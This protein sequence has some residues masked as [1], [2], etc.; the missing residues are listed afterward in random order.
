[1]RFVSP[2]GLALEQP[3]GSPELRAL[4]IGVAG[5]RPLIDD[6]DRRAIA[7]RASPWVGD[8]PLRLVVVDLLAGA[9]VEEVLDVA[10]AL[11]DARG[12]IEMRIA[13][14]RERAA[15]PVPKAGDDCRGCPFVPGCKAHL[16]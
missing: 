2:L 9:L 10:G 7:V 13:V 11:D 1:M 15:D 6:A 4:R 8:R 5:N 14:V 12:W 3:D 16:T